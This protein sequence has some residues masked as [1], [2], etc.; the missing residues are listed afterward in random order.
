MKYLE[1]RGKFIKRKS[2]KD[3]IIENAVKALKD[4]CKDITVENITTVY[5]NELGNLLV[6]IQLEGYKQECLEEILEDIDW[7]NTNISRNVKSKITTSGTEP[8]VIEPIIP[9]A[10]M[11]ISN[12][13]NAIRFNNYEEYKEYAGEQKYFS[14][15]HS[16]CFYSKENQE[17]FQKNGSQHADPDEA[18]SDMVFNTGRELVQVWDNKNQIGYIVPGSF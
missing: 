6:S 18:L 3:I 5:A 7:S 16:H 4:K 9:D 1:N 8:T 15:S 12:N 2:Y 11:V 10:I 13:P 14:S 17:Y